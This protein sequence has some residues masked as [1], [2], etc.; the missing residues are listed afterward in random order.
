MFLTIKYSEL[1]YFL[2]YYPEVVVLFTMKNCGWCTKAVPEM[3]K[4]IEDLKGDVP[5]VQIV[6]NTD[7][8]VAEKENIAGFPSCR[9]YKKDKTFSEH[10]GR[11]DAESY[12]KFI[13]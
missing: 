7:K 12:T 2:E 3:K 8:S 11:R 4:A 5:V 9:R 13:S 1:K 6:Y 10:K